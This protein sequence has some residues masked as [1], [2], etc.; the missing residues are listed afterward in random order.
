MHSPRILPRMDQI[1]RQRPNESCR[2]AI[3]TT[4]LERR[5][6]REREIKG[7]NIENQRRRWRRRRRRCT[8]GTLRETSPQ[9]THTYC[10]HLSYPREIQAFTKFCPTFLNMCTYIPVLYMYIHKRRDVSYPRVV[11]FY[12]NGGKRERVWQKNKKK[13]VRKS[14]AISF[15][16]LTLCASLESCLN[17]ATGGTAEAMGETKK[18]SILVDF[19]N[20]NCNG[21]NQ[22]YL[23]QVYCVCSYLVYMCT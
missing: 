18:G 23:W 3:P 4:K 13:R 15:T 20:E 19:T 8:N 21:R 10:T 7:E 17:A 11:N 16:A 22:V 9:D 14:L 12:V 5:R 1:S 2:L 6:D